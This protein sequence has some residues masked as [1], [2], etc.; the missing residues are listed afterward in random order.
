MAEH[1]ASFEPKTVVSA[2][3]RSGANCCIIAGTHHGFMNPISANYRVD[4]AYEQIAILKQI[5]MKKQR[6]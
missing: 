3:A 5:I 1:E 6:V 4:V 2:I